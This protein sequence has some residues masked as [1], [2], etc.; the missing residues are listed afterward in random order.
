METPGAPTARRRAFVPAILTATR[1][2]LLPA[3]ILLWLHDHRL[4][5]LGLYV[6]ILVSDAVDGAV[7]RRLGAVTRFGACA[8]VIADMIVILGLLSVLAVVR[9]IPWW[10]PVPPAVVAAVFFA[11]SSRG[12]PSYDPVGRHYGTML[13]VLIG[14]LLAGIGHSLSSAVCAA[15]L[16]FSLMVLAGR[17]IWLRRSRHLGV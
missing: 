7:A 13:Y 9:S 2:I 14:V 12:S 10:A 17:V 15:I 4:A 6:L 16:A 3:V 5:A 1:L 11:S 8:D